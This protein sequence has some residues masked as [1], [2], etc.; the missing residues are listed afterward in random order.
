MLTALRVWPPDPFASRESLLSRSSSSRS[1]LVHREWL[2]LRVRKCAT[3]LK[4]SLVYALAHCIARGDIFSAMNRRP[5]RMQLAAERVVIA[6]LAMVRLGV[7]V[8]GCANVLKIVLG[9]RRF[10]GRQGVLG[11]PAGTGEKVPQM[12]RPR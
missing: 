12:A 4:T 5:S 8:C 10:V 1:R 11:R 9:Q 3:S 2:E 7:R 6:K